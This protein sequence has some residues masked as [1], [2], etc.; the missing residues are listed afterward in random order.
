[1]T[2]VAQG[3]ALYAETHEIPED[4]KKL[5]GVPAPTA[6]ITSDRWSVQLVY[7]NHSQSPLCPVAGVVTG[8]TAKINGLTVEISS[9]DGKWSSGPISVTEEGTFNCDVQLPESDEPKLRG[10][11][12]VVRN[13]T[14]EEL[15]SAQQ[16]NIWHPYVG[17]DGALKVATS[18]RVAVVGN[19]T[20][21]LITRGTDLPG[22]GKQS[23]ET[24]RRLRHGES[25]D[26]LHVSVVQSVIDLVGRE[27]AHADACFHVGTLKI[28]ARDER[29]T[30]DLP[31]GTSVD[32]TLRQDESRMT[33]VKAFIPLLD[34]VFDATF[35]T[36]SYNVTHEQLSGRLEQLRKDLAKGEQLQTR[37]PLPEAK[38]VLET[39]RRLDSLENI[40]TELQRAREGN[41]EALYGAY[42]QI[43]Q[44]R[45]TLHHFQHIHRWTEIEQRIDD[46]RGLA[47]EGLEKDELHTIEA[48][49]ASADPNNDTTFAR[50][51]ESLDNLDWRVRRRPVYDLYVDL[52][53]ISGKKVTNYQHEV[54]KKALALWK[55]LH[56][57]GG[58][59]ALTEDDLASIISMRRKIEE[60]YPE[61]NEWRTEDD[62]AIPQNPFDDLS[63]AGEVT[64]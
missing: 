4:I 21:T 42:K 8:P 34:E 56:D 3:A 35:T 7:Q 54:F 22:E 24:T 43:L 49:Y 5:L 61:L 25:G 53:A 1:M 64:F 45:G 10:F 62:S 15:A 29:V 57:K 30:Q 60:A 28:E 58:V 20:E 27:T 2:A 23:F 63:K 51:T 39:I 55:G 46:L 13:S 44:L 48:D 16:P 40:A 9:A 12:T 32:V 14:G 19:R 37:R 52:R 31:E 18:L 47:E 36:S 33:S 6:G 17:T 50:V 59:E 26:V 38:V 11:V 41:R